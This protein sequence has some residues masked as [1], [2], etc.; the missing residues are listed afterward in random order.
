[1]QA[2]P[3]KHLA[4]DV[5]RALGAGTL[6]AATTA[7]VLA[8]LDRCVECRQAGVALMGAHFAARL[9]AA[10]APAGT[11]AEA[12]TPAETA[13]S[14]P[15]PILPATTPY[16][17]PN[18][19]PE[20]R[21][22]PQYEVIREL[23]RGGM[24]VVYLSRNKLMDRPEVLKVVNKQILDQP[25]TAERFLREIRAAARLSHANIVTAYS[26]VQA[27]DLLAFAMEYVEGETLEQVVRTQGPLPVANACYYTLQV[28][29]GLQ[30]A[31]D[32]GL[33][34]RD[35]KPQNL[36]LAR[37]GKKHVVK[38]LDFGLAKATR[39]GEAA[40]CGLT[41]TGMMMGT[42]D[43][44]APEQTLDAARADIRA[45]IYS[46]GCTLYYLL[47]GKPPFQAKSQ[48]ELLQA[49]HSK[50]A[51]P[52]DQVRKDVPV[53]LAAIVAK[54]M[55]KDPA[56]RY[57]K[58]VEV[59]QALGPF[60]KSGLKQLPPAPLPPAQVLPVRTVLESNAAGTRAGKQMAGPVTADKD[61]IVEVIPLMT[62]A[63][64]NKLKP[65]RRRRNETEEREREP[66]MSKVGL[67]IAL[68]VGGV[69]V[70]GILGAAVTVALL[71]GSRSHDSSSAARAIG[72]DSFEAALSPEQDFLI[73]GDRL[74][75]W[76]GGPRVV[77]TSNDFL[78]NQGFVRVYHLASGR[79][80]T[81]PLK[82]DNIVTHAEF[83]PDGKRLLTT[84]KDGTV[85]V[86]DSGTGNALCPPIR[87]TDEVWYAAF[88]PDGM[89]FATASK[90]STA[91]VWDTATGQAVSPPLQHDDGQVYMALFSPDGKRVVTAGFDGTARIWDAVTG[92]Q[93]TAPLLHAGYV[94]HA[95][96][97]PD[98][99]RV[100]TCSFDKT[101]RVWDAS[102]GK[103]VSPPLTH[104]DSVWYAAF[105]PDG[106]QVVT[107]SEDNTARVWDGAT[108]WA[109]TQPLQHEWS[110]TWATF[111]PDGKQVATAGSAGQ[112]VW[113]A[114][115]GAA[116][117][118]FA[119]DS[120][121][122]LHPRVLFHPGGKYLAATDGSGAH[123]WDAQTGKELKEVVISSE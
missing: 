11:V 46:L 1:M 2:T 63:S 28:A 4:S 26:A 95:S 71:R 61:E 116:E 88:S 58:P 54:M 114:G 102:T 78:D 84:C 50:E 75:H 99:K 108:G 49:H 44:I 30:H 85:H 43:Y 117:K 73:A 87:H 70:L 83:S 104:D 93:L 51:T 52:L 67:F 76:Q 34:H 14:G 105:S 56:R 103:A 60:A 123:L 29:Q 32:K 57:Q 9:R 3:T 106:K 24:G 110:P 86:W 115:T 16:A 92:T 119:P 118:Q 17:S 23:G 53:E 66:A 22:H 69:V 5:L 10:R 27:G 36:I 77:L 79:A 64:K 12:L 6:D 48:F 40:D 41:G 82:H 80:L 94:W 112:A 97:S 31:F 101:A 89:R 120:H 33:V 19:L 39:E 121:G 42:P 113:D 37:E 21:D 7:V 8:H 109:I 96:F 55:A 72:T 62:P 68:A 38:I 90:D 15:P 47:T 81:P 25:E 98:G 65:R 45:D 100:V 111:T 122:G 74:V 20:L 91:R 35:I 107:T 18:V 13:S 59:A